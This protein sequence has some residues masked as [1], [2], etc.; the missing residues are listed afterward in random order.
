MREINNGDL[1]GMPN[2]LANQKY[3]GLYYNTLEKDQKYPNGESPNDFFLRIKR[4]FDILVKNHEDVLVV[5]HSGVINIL[6]CIANNIEFSN[7]KQK[8]SIAHAKHIVIAVVA[9]IPSVIIA[10]VGVQYALPRVALLAAQ[11][12]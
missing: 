11:A 10:V 7:K 9:V 2:E 5:T 8:I 4:A 6:Y 3:P 1:A 12:A